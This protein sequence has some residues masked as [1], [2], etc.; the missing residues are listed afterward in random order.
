MPI[1]PIGLNQSYYIDKINNQQPPI[2]IFF[3]HPIC[4]MFDTAKTTYG[5]AIADSNL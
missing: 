3:N 5:L 4:S 1:H 2:G